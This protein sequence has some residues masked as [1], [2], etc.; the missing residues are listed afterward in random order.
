MDV[1]FRQA[2]IDQCKEANVLRGI[3]KFVCDCVDAVFEI[4]QRDLRY[5][6][7]DVLC[8][9]HCVE[10]VVFDL[11]CDIGASFDELVD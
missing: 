7:A 8:L 4:G 5:L 11:S 10:T 2:V 6:A 1:F 9:R 3:D